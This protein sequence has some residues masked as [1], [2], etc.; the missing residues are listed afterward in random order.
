MRCKSYQNSIEFGKICFDVWST[1]F[2]KKNMKSRRRACHCICTNFF[3]TVILKSQWDEST[4]RRDIYN[5]QYLDRSY[6]YEEKYTPRT[7]RK[8]VRNLRYGVA[9]KVFEYWSIG[10]MA[11]PLINYFIYLCISKCRLNAG[12]LLKIL[13]ARI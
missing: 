12:C 13:L 11:E 5:K 8:D 10:W 9:Y 2:L 7:F 1:S 4:H 3:A 6:I